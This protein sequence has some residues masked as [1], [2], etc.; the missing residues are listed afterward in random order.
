MNRKSNEIKPDEN[1]MTMIM[2]NNYK[3]S[4]QVSF[5]TCCSQHSF[6]PS[7]RM[8]WNPQFSTLL[9]LSFSCFRLWFCFV[10]DYFDDLQLFSCVRC[11]ISSGSY[12]EMASAYDWIIIIVYTRRGPMHWHCKFTDRIELSWKLRYSHWDLFVGWYMAYELCAACCISY[13]IRHVIVILVCFKL[14]R[15]LAKII[16]LL[17][18][19]HFSATYSAEHSVDFSLRGGIVGEKTLISF[20]QITIA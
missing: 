19:F 20:I 6:P 14:I 15:T 17:Y 5:R 16:S 4:L 12:V 1:L 3:D 11:H 7:K 13:H 2:N 9:R 10:F 8:P 18:V